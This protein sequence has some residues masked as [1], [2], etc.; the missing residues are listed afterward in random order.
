MQPLA[1]MD[2]PVDFLR[3][4]AKAIDRAAAQHL[5]HCG[6]QKFEMLLGSKQRI[7]AGDPGQD[8]VSAVAE[9]DLPVIEQQHDRDRGSRLDDLREARA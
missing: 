5:A 7:A 4:A 8:H 9:R 3:Q 1:V 2:Q 6:A